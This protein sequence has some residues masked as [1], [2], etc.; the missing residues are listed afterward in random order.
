MIP[1]FNQRGQS[2]SHITAMWDKRYYIRDKLYAAQMSLMFQIIEWLSEF[3]T[4]GQH[5][6]ILN[7]YNLY[8]WW[9]ISS[10]GMNFLS[11]INRNSLVPNLFGF[12][13][14]F[15]FA[16]LWLLLP[17]SLNRVDS[18][19]TFLQ[20]YVRKR[21][22]HWYWLKTV[23]PHSR[24]HISSRKLGQALIP[25]W[26][27]DLLVWIYCRQWTPMMDSIWTASSEFGTYR[28]CEQ[29]RFRLACASA[30][31]PQNLRCSL[32]QV[33]S[34]EEPSDRKPDLWP[35]WMAGHAQLKFVMTECSKTQIRLTGPICPSGNWIMTIAKP[36]I[37]L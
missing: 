17:C 26:I 18:N 12:P 22:D 16:S 4:V 29:Q 20:G 25:T 14:I 33:V 21:I 19:D 30:Q 8:L 5:L 9:K 13:K 28:L 27:V 34:Q 31:S 35:L 10:V 7:A 6:E 32:I 3:Y 24:V 11:Y 2:R 36:W 1:I 15:G 23:N 37:T